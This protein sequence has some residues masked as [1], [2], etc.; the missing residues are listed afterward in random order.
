LG[1]ADVL[2]PKS[3]L[4]KGGL[5]AETLV[6]GRAAVA[7]QQISEILGVPGV[8]LLGPLPAAI[9]T[10]TTCSGALAADTYQSIAAQA[11]LATMTRPAA[12]EVMRARGMNEP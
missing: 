11:F 3:V 2:A 5:A 12:G 6:D 10:Y 4:V 7:L 8:T 9:Q 1:I